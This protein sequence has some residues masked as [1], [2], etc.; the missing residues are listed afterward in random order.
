MS[1]VSRADLLR[2]LATTPLDDVSTMSQQQAAMLGFEYRQ[3]QV[4]GLAS[5]AIATAAALDYKDALPTS[6]LNQASR[7]PHYWYVERCESVEARQRQDKPRSDRKTAS[8]VIEAKPR[9]LSAT[10][11]AAAFSNGYWQNIFDAC[12][13]QSRP[14]R[15]PDMPRNIRHISQ[16]KPLKKLYF[17]Q[18]R[19]WQTNTVLLLDRSA[20]HYPVW[21]DMF[22]AAAALRTLLGERLQSIALTQGIDG[23]WLDM[24]QDKQIEP[25]DLP[26]QAHIL[27]LS[28]FGALDDAQ[29]G[30]SWRRR[31]DQLQHQ[32]HRL[33]LLSLCWLD[34]P[35]TPT[36][37]VINLSRSQS[38][39]TLYAAL[40]VAWLPSL[41][42]LRALRQTISPAS[43]TDELMVYADLNIQSPEPYLNITYEHLKA[44][45]QAWDTLDEALQQ[46]L[47]RIAKQWRH[48]LPVT[49]REVERLQSTFLQGRKVTMEDFPQLQQLMQQ[50]D[51]EHQ[52]IQQSS[53][54]LDFM[55]GV[56]PFSV[57]LADSP[58]A[59]YMQPLLAGAQKAA[60]HF[61]HELPLRDEGL[62]DEAL[63]DTAI[64]RGLVQRHTGLQ[65]AEHG[66]QSLLP[67]S[68]KPY[69]VRSRKIF[70]GLRDG[71][72]LALL[73]RGL[74]W[75]LE[76]MQ[77][78]A[79]AE[80]I[81][82]SDGRI[83]AAHAQGAIF[84]LWPADEQHAVAEW[85]LIE[86]AFSWA[87]GSG[88]DDIGLW[89]NLL[90]QRVNYRLRW[91]PPGTFMM[92]SPETRNRQGKR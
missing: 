58:M 41:A 61:D 4:P 28:T 86:N 24:Q 54:C 64:A 91:I 39:Q 44:I 89:A 49:A 50:L 27:I 81:W 31:L 32:G 52:Q 5:G 2:L 87:S 76:A 6:I 65:L 69:D 84:Q 60:A 71:Q 77:K 66:Q 48:D 83:H 14:T 70:S 33:T 35:S 22:R 56:L 9:E 23:G 38:P 55:R 47:L 25:A 16:A 88:I 75:Q 73:D 45:F 82:M 59:Q 78:P 40:A 13:D 11:A 15:Q 79:W 92:G 85:L 19:H 1:L 17:Q 74:H 36:R 67:L 30:D 3:G 68:T 63:S 29:P 51:T 42:Q 26:P 72:S 37:Q 46:Q 34:M 12:R 10:T 7:T 53:M 18:R 57:L 43:V 8:Q 62:S 21:A 80:R 20:Q 90:V